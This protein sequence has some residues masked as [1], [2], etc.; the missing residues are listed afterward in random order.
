MMRRRRSGS[1]RRRSSGRLVRVSESTPAGRTRRIAS[2]TLSGP[3]PP[4]RITGTPT[5]AGSSRAI[6]GATLS[7]VS[8]ASSSTIP[9]WPASSAHTSAASS[10]VVIP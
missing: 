5:A 8:I 2:T 7:Q 4:A 10:G 6:A 3:R 1:L 9:T